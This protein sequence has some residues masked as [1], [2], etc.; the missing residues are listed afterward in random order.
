MCDDV[1]NVLHKHRVMAPRDAYTVSYLVGGDA[2]FTALPFT[3]WL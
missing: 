1:T 2:C 3:R